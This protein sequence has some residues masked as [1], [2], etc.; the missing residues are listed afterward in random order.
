MAIPVERTQHPR[1]RPLEAELGF[2]RWFTDHLFRADWDEERGWHGARVE[3][4]GPIPLDPAASVLH[5]GQAAFEGLKA[6]PSQ[7]AATG[8]ALFRPRTHAARLGASA[9]RLSMP[10]PPEALLLEGIR[11][12]LRED[13]DWMPRAPGTAIY[14]RPLLFATEPFLGV[15]PSRTF[16]LIVLLSPVGGYFAGPPRPLRI[17][18]EE[19]RART[20][21]GGIGEAKAAANY[22]ASLLAAS[23]AKAQ[24]YDQVLWLDGAEHRFVEEIGTMNLFVK[25]SGRVVTPALSGTFLAGATRGAAIALGRE[26]GLTVEERR[27]PFSELAAAARAGTLEEAFGTGTAALTAAIG[28]FDW[29]G[30]R[31][32]VPSPAD[33]VA[34]RLRDRIAAIQRGET[35]DPFGWMEPV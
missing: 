23:E 6:F 30:E 20:A 13:A 4:Y 2:G 11:A 34:D 12:L 29:R 15:R 31:L 27:L 16:A 19:D 8:M 9:R 10:A 18:V 14:V 28:E 26:M 24:G 17:R 35:H 32:A 1:P 3:P 33:S 7:T 21:R 22:V 5:Y 25:I